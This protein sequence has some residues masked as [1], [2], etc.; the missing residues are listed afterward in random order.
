MP[1]KHLY[2]VRHA[3][4][5]LS[6]RDQ[7]DLTSRGQEQALTVALALRGLRFTRLI[8]SPILRAMQTADIIAELFPSITR[9]VDER[10]SECIPEVPDGYRDYFTQHYPDLTDE[11]MYDCA[12]AL[13]AVCRDHFQP[14]AND[15]DEY[16]MIVC[17]GNVIRYL[18][19]QV[20][21]SDSK[22]WMRMLINNC[23]LSRITIDHDGH[24]FVVSHNDIGH[25]P[26]HLLT[27]L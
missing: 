18:V 20:L 8:S 26:Q 3:Q 4:Y 19:S 15:R 7:G 25:L 17:H 12:G 6:K 23:G 21:E 13:Q 10:L 14:P 24:T 1:K 27:E 2:L 11:Q 16:V 22:F 5:D 9:E